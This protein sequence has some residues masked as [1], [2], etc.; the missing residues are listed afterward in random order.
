[1]KIATGHKVRIEFDLQV[2]GGEKIEHSTVEYIQGE[3]KILPAI[4]KRLEGLS[5]GQEKAGEIPAKEAINEESLPT[6]EIPRAEFPKEAKL[7]EGQVFAAKGPDGNSV[8]FKVL[9]I[10]SSKVTVRFLHP[11]LGKDLSFKVKVLM[12]E[13][14]KAKKRAVA[15][16][17]PPAAALGIDD[18]I[19][20]V[21]EA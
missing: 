20:D 15:V 7:T 3:G 10:D 18:V 1:M 9:K 13:D 6:K 16:P 14:P 21:K 11:L 19:D 2:K 12:I 5:I 4:E 8:S 17:P